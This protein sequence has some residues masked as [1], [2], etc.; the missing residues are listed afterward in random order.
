MEN[1][2][3]PGVFKETPL[4]VLH[5]AYRNARL[6]FRY[7]SHTHWSI[8]SQSRSF[9]VQVV[10]ALQLLEECLVCIDMKG[11]VR[12]AYQIQNSI[13][14]LCVAIRQ[15]PQDACIMHML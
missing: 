7:Y 11:R 1:A 13:I 6:D 5:V 2:F 10:Q 12:A 15:D 8:I 3:H 9:E 4:Y 14:S